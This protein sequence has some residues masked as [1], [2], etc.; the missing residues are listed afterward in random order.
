MYPT[1]KG[2]LFD[3][4]FKKL[5]QVLKNMR[6]KKLQFFLKKQCCEHAC[7]VSQNLVLFFLQFF[8]ARIFPELEHWSLEFLQL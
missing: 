6:A 1:W 8:F 7:I 5:A 2:Y 3:G 4:F